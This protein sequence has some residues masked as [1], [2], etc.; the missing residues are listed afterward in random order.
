MSAAQWLPYIPRWP[1]LRAER[2]LHPRLACLAR[3]TSAAQ[4]CAPRAAGAPAWPSS[5]AARVAPVPPH[6]T[7]RTICAPPAAAPRSAL[8]DAGI[9]GTIPQPN[10]WQLPPKLKDLQL[11][12][13]GPEKAQR[14]R[15]AGPLPP[16]WRL[17][18]GACAARRRRR[19]WARGPGLW[20]LAGAGSTQLCTLQ[21]P[22]RSR[23][24][25]G[26]PGA[27]PRR[28]SPD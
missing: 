2:R 28:D 4:P 17:P 27:R 3:C 12:T 18:D 11:C 23:A 14:N 21:P 9:V 19:Q 22:P 5:T 8:V 15:L 20:G 1:P 7:C 26:W 24:H 6:P 16:G 25:G 13:T 10:G